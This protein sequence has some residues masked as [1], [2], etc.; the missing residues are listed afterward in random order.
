VAIF[1]G[2][3]D[4]VIPVEMGRKL[5]QESPVVEFFAINGAGHVSVPTRAREKI[6]DWM[7]R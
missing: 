7:N 2:T 6:I 5:A 4:G 1:H 3:N